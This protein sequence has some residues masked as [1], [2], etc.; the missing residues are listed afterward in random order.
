MLSGPVR[1]NDSLNEVSEK[2]LSII[3]ADFSQREGKYVLKLRESSSP[4][5]SV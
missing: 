3:I 5:E 4:E 2:N 1:T